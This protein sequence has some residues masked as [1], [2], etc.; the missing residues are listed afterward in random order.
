[1]H[2]DRL[3]ALAAATDGGEEGDVTARVE[4]RR[5]DARERPGRNVG[6]DAP[7]ERDRLRATRGGDEDS[8]DGPGACDGG[9]EGDLARIVERR[10]RVPAEPR[11][12]TAPRRPVALRGELVDCRSRGQEEALARPA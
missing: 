2:V 12:H 1:I 11:E 5:V 9:G 4:R 6:R 7:G 10:D 3:E 8:L